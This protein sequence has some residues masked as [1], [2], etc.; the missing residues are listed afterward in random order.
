MNW[1]Q[2]HWDVLRKAVEDRGL[3]HLI[4]KDDETALKNTMDNLEG[5]EEVFDPLMGSYCRINNQM[6]V[7]LKDMGQADLQTIMRCPLC[8]LVEH[9]QPE[10]VENWVNGVTDQAQHYAVEKGLIT[11]Q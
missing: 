2:P 4:A 3:S 7:D 6:L 10:Q 8:L 1:C 11:K 5:D 9:G